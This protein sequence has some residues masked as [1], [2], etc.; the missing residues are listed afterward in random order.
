MKL[1][2]MKALELM[3]SIRPMMNSL[4]KEES[5]VFPQRANI[6]AKS[7]VEATVTPLV[8]DSPPSSEATVRKARSPRDNNY[9]SLML[10]THRMVRILK[11]FHH[12]LCTFMMAQLSCFS[13]MLQVVSGLVTSLLV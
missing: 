3:A 1:V 6:E 4:L 5:S 2:P 7:R 13:Y 12:V 9:H 11:L 10:F 8:L